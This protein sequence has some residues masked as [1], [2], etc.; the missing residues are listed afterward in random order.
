MSGSR[1]CARTVFCSADSSSTVVLLAIAIIMSAMSRSTFESA[2]MS[3][4]AAMMSPLAAAAMA[5]LDV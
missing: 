3:F 1:K 5:S 2:S 4:R